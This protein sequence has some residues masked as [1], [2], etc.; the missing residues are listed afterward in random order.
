M[1]KLK[2]KLEQI[3]KPYYDYIKNIKEK[4]ASIIN[5][6]DE[7]K[8]KIKNLENAIESNRKYLDVKLEILREKR[9]NEIEKYFLKNKTPMKKSMQNSI[10]S[11]YEEQAKKM[12]T[13]TYEDIKY[14]KLEIELLN[15]RI[16]FLEA[17]EEK[18]KNYRRVYVKEIIQIKDNIIFKLNQEKKEI[19]QIQDDLK[20]EKEQEKLT[21]SKLIEY[22]EMLEKKYYC[23][24]EKLSSFKCKND[25]DNVIMNPKEYVILSDKL[26]ETSD[27]IVN[28]KD[29]TE[30]VNIINKLDEQISY[31]EAKINV[32]N[33]KLKEVEYT[34][35]ELEIRLIP[36]L[37]WEQEEYDRRNKLE[38]GNLDLLEGKSKP[39]I[40]E[41]KEAII[42]EKNDK[43]IMFTTITFN[44]PITVVNRVKPK[45]LKK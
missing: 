42:Q 9:I 14:K 37:P 24:K 44:C 8:N 27:R 12:I 1:I 21:F 2:E 30:Y 34:E 31:L 26:N 16:R 41:L 15:K 28:I 35:E 25:E 6:I 39:I 13:D 7:I 18:N 10:E 43:S 22:K 38:I 23:L 29:I 4:D 33:N 20:N 19:L 11:L 36:L 32:I 45:V 3:I 5:E 40:E 17:K